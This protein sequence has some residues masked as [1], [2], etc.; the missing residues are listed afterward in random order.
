MYAISN[1]QASRLKA[2][3]I[4]GG[5]SKDVLGCVWRDAGLNFLKIW[6]RG[7]VYFDPPASAAVI[8]ALLPQVALPGYAE[9]GVVV[10]FVKGCLGDHPHIT[11]SVDPQVGKEVLAIIGGIDVLR[12][13]VD[14]DL[15]YTYFPYIGM[16]T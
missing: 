6:A 9:D 2:D 13:R 8:A 5:R 14:S 15:W 12:R 7:T 16:G 4:D 11:L 3:A 1:G 10:L